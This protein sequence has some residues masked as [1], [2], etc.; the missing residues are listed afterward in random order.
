MSAS[1]AIPAPLSVRPDPPGPSPDRQDEGAAPAPAA[2]FNAG[3][4]LEMIV[5]EAHWC[6][7]QVATIAILSSAC[8]RPEATY[9]LRSCRYLLH[10]DVAIML[11]AL[12]YG[13]EI[14]LRA[15]DV[16]KLAGL[17]RGVAEAQK[18]L[19]PMTALPVLSATQRNALKS[20]AA[21]WRRLAAQAGTAIAQ[22]EA[23]TRAR[24]NGYYH[25]DA[26]TLR[27]YL[28]RAA[29]GDMSDVDASGVVRT[30]EL[31]QRRKS[32][33]V[34]IDGTCVLILPTGSIRARLN[35]VSLNGLSVT[36]EQPLEARQKLVVAL[37][38]GRKLEAV[39]VRRQGAKA[40]LSLRHSLKATDPLFRS[41]EA[42]A[43]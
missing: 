26:E 2:T 13:D 30:P 36:A 14:G 1:P 42:P 11:L 27:H 8:A 28:R 31:T 10:N 41:G 15:D 6:V 34:A 20:H 23:S 9:S 17:Y 33:R 25:K 40:G 32:P 3:F 18:S 22:I 12:R 7:M 21:V 5:C 29:D 38:D 16:A 35:D 24:L 19:L 43:A 37:E 4:L 39:V